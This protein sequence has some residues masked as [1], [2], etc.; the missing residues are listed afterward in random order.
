MLVAVIVAIHLT[1]SAVATVASPASHASC[2]GFAR[3][4][5]AK[6]ETNLNSSASQA[7]YFAFSNTYLRGFRGI[8][9]ISK[10]LRVAGAFEAEAEQWVERAWSGGT[11]L[12]FGNTT[13]SSLGNHSS[14][15]SSGGNQS[16]NATQ[17]VLG[18]A[19]SCLSRLYHGVM[20]GFDARPPSFIAEPP[21]SR[22]NGLILLSGGDRNA[23]L[24]ERVVDNH[25]AFAQ[26]HGYAHWW[27]RGNLAKGWLPYWHKVAHLKQAF[28]RFPLARA[29]AW[30][31]DDIVLTN[32]RMGEDMIERAL[33]K[34]N[35]SVIVTR[36]PGSRAGVAVL[37]T[38]VLIVRNDDDGLA[39]LNEMWRRADA[40]RD[41]G[42]VLARSS[43][44]E[45]CLHEQQALQEMLSLAHWRARVAILEQREDGGGTNAEERFDLNTFL[46]WSHFDGERQEELRYDMDAAG[47]AWRRTDFAGHCSGLSP[48]RRALCVAALL[49]AVVS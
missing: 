12:L 48:V 4:L 9:L 11:S 39:V 26:R 37:N 6:V 17:T 47:S 31:D 32:H 25:R 33:R 3:K 24:S 5:E 15:S 29:F 27:H 41:D 8:A 45:G 35:A 28:A 34:T 18:G 7:A 10:G 21:P 43:Q 20:S 1:L 19:L 44:G 46:R 38:G 13:T 22:A 42:L 23:A 49:G 16:S 14:S 2:T 36:D 40:E 30:V